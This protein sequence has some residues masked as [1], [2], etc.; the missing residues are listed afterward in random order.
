VPTPA[1]V[2]PIEFSMPRRLYERLGGH[3]DAIVSIDAMLKSLATQARV[4]PWAPENPWP[5]RGGA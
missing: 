3:A 5:L 2:A 1:I 4:E